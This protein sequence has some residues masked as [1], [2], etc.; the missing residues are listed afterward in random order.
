MSKRINLY[1]MTPEELKRKQEEIN[2]RVWKRA[3]ENHLMTGKDSDDVWPIYDGVADFEGYLASSPRVMFVLKE[4]YDDF[5]ENSQGITVPYGGGWDLPELF[6][7]Q[8]AAKAWPVMTWQRIIYAMY[9]FQHDLH[10]N[11]MDYIRNNPEMG[12]VLLSVCWVNLSKMPRYTTSSDGRWRN[13]FRENWADIFED[14]VK[15]YEPDVIVFG[16]T[17]SEVS[18][19]FLTEGDSPEPVK[20][21]DGRLYINKY[22]TKD[23]RLLVDA[24]HPG[25]RITVEYWVDS[26]IDTLN[27]YQARKNI[28]TSTM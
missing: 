24:Y 28:P 1:Y 18:D 3:L 11:D 8:A 9:G 14:Q 10:Y 5:K 25:A 23:G 22:Y 2:E 16:N 20:A 19:R 15:C 17:F 6:S 27:E 21:P 13:A 26:L 7:K 12:N 4:P